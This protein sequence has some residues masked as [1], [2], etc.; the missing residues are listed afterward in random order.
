MQEVQSGVPLQPFGVILAG[1]AARRLDGA[2]KGLLD[3]AGERIIDRVAT[4]MRPL[5]SRLV[6]VAGSVAASGWLRDADFLVDEQPG[7]GALA[8][9]ATALRATRQDVLAI[10]WDMPF[11]TGAVL[12]PLLVDDDGDVFDA[13]M[14]RTTSGIE[15]LCA[16]Y[17]RS[18]L[19]II[20]AA[21][22]SG[23]RRARDV[24]SLLRVRTLQHAGTVGGASPFMSV[25]TPD[26]LAVARQIAAPEPSPLTL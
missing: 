13:T 24:A 26:D 22:A 14:W 19:P 7:G 12:L 18:A 23:V 4:A 25:N 21:I 9:I 5:V 20:D 1:G 6:I 17:R 3:I 15:P 16:L 11:V 2:A 10:A 8:G